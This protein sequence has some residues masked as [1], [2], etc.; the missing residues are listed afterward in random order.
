MIERPHRDDLHVVGAD[1]KL[2]ELLRRGLRRSVDIGRVQR[3]ILPDRD[4]L[5]TERAVF[6]AGTDQQNARLFR[7]HSCGF[8]Q[9]DCALDI[10]ISGE[11]RLFPRKRDRALCRKMQDAVRL[12]RIQQRSSCFCIENVEI[13]HGAERDAVRG[14][15]LLRELCR[16]DFALFGKL[17]DRIRTDKACRTDN[18]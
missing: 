10:D 9:I 6:L 7:Q 2:R 12:D 17:P 18:Q 3:G 14:D 1:I 5:R 13:M 15:L 11:L 16:M 8:Q 4:L